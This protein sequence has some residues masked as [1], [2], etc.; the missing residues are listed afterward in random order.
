MLWFSIIF[1]V[2]GI[3]AII[4]AFYIYYFNSF[5]SVIIRINEVESDIDDLLR[6]KFDLLNRALGI[7]K[8]FENVKCDILDDLSKL[9]SKNLSS[10][11]FDQCLGEALNEFYKIREIYNETKENEEFIKINIS[12][13]DIEEQI[14]ACRNYYNDNISI[15]NKLIK[16]IPSN[17]I[18]KVLKYNEKPFYDGK[19]MYDDIYND[20]KL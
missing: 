5:Q 8:T 1:F 11:K 10:F 12:L 14:I 18:G 9:K 19:N 17:I 16:T 15:Y 7:I 3:V 20:F 6:N 4:S 13:E 2:I